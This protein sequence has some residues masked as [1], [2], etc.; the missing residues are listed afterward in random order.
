[1]ANEP[2]KE[3][4]KD[5]MK[6][7]GP[8]QGYSFTM[9]NIDGESA[10]QSDGRRVSVD[11]VEDFRKAYIGYTM[12]CEGI[13]IVDYEID[14]NDPNSVQSI[15]DTCDWERASAELQWESLQSALS[16]AC[17]T[18]QIDGSSRV[19]TVVSLSESRLDIYGRYSGDGGSFP[20]PL[21]IS[22]LLSAFTITEQWTSVMG[23][24]EQE[25]EEEARA[26]ATPRVDARGAQW[27]QKQQ[28]HGSRKKVKKSYSQIIVKALL[29]A[30]EQHDSRL[31][32][33]VKVNLGH[34]ALMELKC[35]D[36][37]VKLLKSLADMAPKLTESVCY[38]PD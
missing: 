15:D 21:K 11:Y 14:E 2:M 10:G 20:R 7:K 17:A 1:M 18:M 4:L 6:E 16:A 35:P 25:E 34:E 12:E 26:A 37:G 23:L 8:Q 33:I 30:C 36:A 19:S 13:R 32:W 38:P 9:E 31:L 24:A 22:T 3:I 27:I 5:L 28:L 29:A